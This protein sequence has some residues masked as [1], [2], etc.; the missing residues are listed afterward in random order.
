MGVVLLKLVLFCEPALLWE[1]EMVMMEYM[2][3]TGF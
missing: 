2:V 3:T 1:R